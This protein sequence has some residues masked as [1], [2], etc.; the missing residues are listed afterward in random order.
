MYSSSYTAQ[1]AASSGIIAFA[2]HDA[3]PGEKNVPRHAP[4]I[5]GSDAILI[6]PLHIHNSGEATKT[7]EVREDSAFGRAEEA[8]LA[9]TSC[10]LCDPAS[11]TRLRVWER[12]PHLCDTFG[13][14]VPTH[15]CG[16]QTLVQQLMEKLIAGGMVD[17]GGVGC[18]FF[19]DRDADA[20]MLRIAHFFAEHGFVKCMRHVAGESHWVMQ[21]LGRSHLQAITRLQKPRLV[22]MPREGVPLTDLLVIELHT[23]LEE[24][25]WI[26]SVARDKEAERRVGIR[27]RRGEAPEPEEAARAWKQARFNDETCRSRS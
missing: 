3:Y 27:L 10:M 8:Q 15:V 23:M 25:G 19:S 2:V 7:L 13:K 14:P 20:K 18:V 24:D 21:P 9:L 16:D 17:S 6:A 4:R 22:C 5:S 1:R 26:S 12:A 11:D